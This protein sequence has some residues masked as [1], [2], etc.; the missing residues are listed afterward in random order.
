[1]KILEEEVLSSGMRVALFDES[2]PV[3]GDRWLVK[4][5]C[6][7]SIGLVPEW[8]RDIA[9]TDAPLRHEVLA[10]LGPSLIFTVRKER[11][12][13]DDRDKETVLAELVRAIRQHM[14]GYLELPHFPRKLFAKQYAAMRANC[15]IERQRGVVTRS[16]MEDEGPADFSSLFRD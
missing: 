4:V 1:M 7:A 6:E 2:C 14:V 13:V 3:V 10:R 5:R 11:N 16:E 12:F 15:L 8:G 9:E